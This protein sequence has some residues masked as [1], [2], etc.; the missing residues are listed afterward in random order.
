MAQSDRIAQTGAASGKN[1]LK[2]AEFALV[3]MGLGCLA[4]Y[5]RMASVG[6]VGYLSPAGAPSVDPWYAL[7]TA[8]CLA[9]FA[10]LAL[11]GWRKTLSVSVPSLIF[12]TAAAVA[13]P[14]VFAV[15]EGGELASGFWGESG[16]MP[17]ASVAATGGFAVAVLTGTSAA[18]CPC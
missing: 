7:R 4:G 9:M 8:V 16:T 14:I 13:A 2:R 6:F 12:A 11:N 3:A 10:L 18:T 1:H 5:A 15:S 17:P